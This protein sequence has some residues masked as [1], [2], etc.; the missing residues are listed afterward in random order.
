ME[1]YE[2]NGC[3]VELDTP[4]EVGR[5]PGHHWFSTLHPFGGERYV[6]EVV[7]AA[8][9]AQG[10]WPGCLYTSEDA[11][12]TWQRGLEIDSYGPV[13][14]PLGQGERL[15]MPYEVW[16]LKPGDKRAATAH[17]NILRWPEGGGLTAEPVPVNFL[18]FPRDLAPY[19]EDGLLFVTNGNVLPLADGRLFTTAY[20]KFVG[21]PLYSIQAL[22]SSDGGFNWQFL[23]IVADAATIPGVPEGPCESHNVRLADGRLLCVYRVGSGRNWRFHKSLSADEGLTWT[24]PERME[25]AWSVEPILLS[26]ENGLILLAGGRWGIF[27][28]VCTDGAGESWQPVNLAAHHNQC[29][30]DPSLRYGEET[31]RAEVEPPVHQTTSYNSLAAVGPDEALIC[32]DWLARGWQ[33]GPNEAGDLDKV[34]AVRARIIR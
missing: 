28:W 6:C 32:Y 20:G 10:T 19:R 17:G 25:D 13:S 29:L 27:L 2:L 26:L 15:L 24:P 3:T 8:D 11:G 30:A 1:R 31:V 22:T 34:F 14:L 7:V 21:D 16:P 4:V 5:A 23:S 12:R 18:G 9:E 33:G